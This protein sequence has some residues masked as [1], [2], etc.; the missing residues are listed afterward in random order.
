MIGS[1]NM[2]RSPSLALENKIF[3]CSPKANVSLSKFKML[4]KS[5]PSKRLAKSKRQ[6]YHQSKLSNFGVNYLPNYNP[7]MPRRAMPNLAIASL[8]LSAEAAANVAR[9]NNSVGTKFS[10]SALNQLPLLTRTPCSTAARKTSSSISRMDLVFAA[11]C[12]C[13]STVSQSY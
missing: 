5:Y 12:L 13:Q 10:R 3:F 6:P 4:P 7:K 8:I 1:C 2:T 11:G 9:K